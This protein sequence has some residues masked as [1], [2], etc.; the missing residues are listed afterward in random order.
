M[1][2]PNI[3]QGAGGERERPARYIVPELTANTP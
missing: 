1:K 3:R 2:N